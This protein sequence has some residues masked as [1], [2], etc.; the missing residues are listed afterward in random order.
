[1]DSH[2]AVLASLALAI[3]LSP[4]TLVLGL[5]IAGDKK[6]PRL[7]SLAF[8][9]G[10]VLGIAFATGIGLWI[11]HISDAGAT[12]SAQ[13][14]WPGFIVR[15][16]IAG[17]LLTIG[18]YRAVN[19]MRH[20][21]IAD[22]SEPEHKPGRL[23]TALTE[24]FPTVMRQLDPGADLPV[25]RRV[26][27]AG[28]AGFAICGLHPKVFPIA[29]AAGHQIMQIDPRPLRT[30]GIVVFALI[31][32]VPAV[33]PAVIELVKPGATVRIKQAYERIMRA[34][35]RWITALLLV[36]AGL[37]VGFDAWRG[38]PGW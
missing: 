2:L 37:F 21:P 20:T 24:R 31:A 28:L 1:M 26:T 14:G 30:L 27:R 13:H 5:V 18:V 9:V 33:V 38:M 34:H 35:G 3:F 17:A 23:A 10:A 19:A 32:V 29:I 7:T 16:C 36:G 22:V 6:V 11:A 25:S 4:E 15:V 12:E 8:A